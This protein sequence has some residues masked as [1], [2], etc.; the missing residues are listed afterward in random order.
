M[1]ARNAFDNEASLLLI[2]DQH[3]HS[4]P[5]TTARYIG[6]YEEDDNTTVDYVRY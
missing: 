4:N 1:F 2:Q 6:T 5:K 3:R